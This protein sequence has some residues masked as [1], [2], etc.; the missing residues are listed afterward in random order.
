MWLC[1]WCSSCKLHS[2]LSLLL[3]T[4]KLLNQ[5]FLWVKLKSS[6]RKFYGRH[7]DLVVRSGISVSQNDHGYVPIVENISRSFPHPWLITGFVTIL[8][9][10]VPLMEQELVILP[11][12][13]SSPPVFSGVRVTRSL[14]SW[15]CVAD[16]CLS[17]L[18]FSFGHCVVCSS[19]YGFRLPFLYLQTLLVKYTLYHKLKPVSRTTWQPSNL[20]IYA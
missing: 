9:R 12:N 3:L 4:R 18:Y 7:Q 1:V 11:D 8:T 6:L 16:R 2:G 14:V 15:V 19:I 17:L 13:L 10:R 5:G 20:F